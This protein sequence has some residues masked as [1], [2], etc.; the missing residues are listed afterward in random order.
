MSESHSSTLS[1]QFDNLEQQRSASELGMWIFLVTEVLF[2]GGLFLAYSIYR[3]MF[4]EAFAQSSMKLDLWLGAFNTF[5]L[6]TSSL[7]M[8]LAVN[9]AE[10][11]KKVRILIFLFMTMTLGAI[12]LGIK[13]IEYH[14][15]FVEHLIPGAGFQLE[16]GDVQHAQLFFF[17]YFAMTGLHGLHM[18][19]GLG[20]LAVL[21]IMTAMGKFSAEYHNPIYVSGLYWHFV[22]IVWIFLYPLLY[23]IGAR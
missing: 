22:D 17:L 12:F 10:E 8:A 18:I 1:H 5:V 3:F 21:S 14:H 20:V 19:I 4:P 7:T 15:K 6:L 9:A 11:G 13:G 16:G 23:L 2:F